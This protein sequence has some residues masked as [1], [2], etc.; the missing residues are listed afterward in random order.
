MDICCTSGLVTIALALVFIVW[1]YF[2]SPER[3]HANIERMRWIR[4][5]SHYMGDKAY[6]RSQERKASGMVIARRIYHRLA[7]FLAYVNAMWRNRPGR[8]G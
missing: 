1:Q 8:L 2:E 6:D 4:H 7:D 3:F 5:R